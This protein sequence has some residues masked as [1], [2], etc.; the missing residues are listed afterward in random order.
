MSLLRLVLREIL[1]RKL[2][3]AL[4]VVSVCVA[5]ACLVGALAILDKH[6]AR[7]EQIIVAKEVETK[8]K[9]AALEDDYR[10][11]TLKMGFN[12]LIL[13]K[14]QSLSDLYSD[15]FAA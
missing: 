8:Q 11:L 13:P 14:D 12:V 2:N 9:M 3:F 1:H 15:D 5:V 10:K 4:G 6:D 7:T